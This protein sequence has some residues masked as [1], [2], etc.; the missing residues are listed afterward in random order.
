MA[1][2]VTGKKRNHWF[3]EKV[4]RNSRG[5]GFLSWCTPPLFEYTGFWTFLHLW[6]QAIVLELALWSGWPGASAALAFTSGHW[7]HGH[8]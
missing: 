2:F 5:L 6:R 4:E 8:V 3:L 1:D 7:G